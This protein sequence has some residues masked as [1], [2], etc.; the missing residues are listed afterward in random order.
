MKRLLKKYLNKETVLYLIFGV[1]T[2]IVSF[3]VYY[4]FFNFIGLDELIANI[5]SW[6]AAVVFAYFTNKVFVFESRSWALRVIIPELI[7]F[8]GARVLSFLFEEG[9]IALT[10]KT[11]GMNELLSKAIASVVVIILN[12]FASKFI[13]FKKKQKGSDDDNESIQ[14]SDDRQ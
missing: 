4:L 8:F 3:G 1:L 11:W 7:S 14:S 12:Y 13:I 9:F 2:T 5:I 10:C 6:I